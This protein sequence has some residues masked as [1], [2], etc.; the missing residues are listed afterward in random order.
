MSRGLI[1]WPKTQGRPAPCCLCVIPI[2]IGDTFVYMRTED[3]ELA[4]AHTE[5]A[6]G[7]EDEEGPDA[8]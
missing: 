3:G 1:S 6:E 2:R 5:C 8:A 4:V 7:Q